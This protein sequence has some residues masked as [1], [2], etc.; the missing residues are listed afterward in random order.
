[1]RKEWWLRYRFGEKDSECRAVRWS[2][3]RVSVLS[4]RTV[5][6]AEPTVV[7]GIDAF[8]QAALG[9]EAGDVVSFTVQHL[10]PR[11]YRGVQLR[12]PVIPHI[13]LGHVPQQVRLIWHHAGDLIQPDRGGAGGRQRFSSNWIRLNCTGCGL[14]CKAGNTP[15]VRADILCSFFAALCTPLVAEWAV[16]LL[17]YEELL[18]QIVMLT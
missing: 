5:A 15:Q 7:G 17:H 13:Q 11:E 2:K 18:C 3:G 6:V 1:M 10:Q 4:N 16:N 14:S 9:L 8:E 12:Q